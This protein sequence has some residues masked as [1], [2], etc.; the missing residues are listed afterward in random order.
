MKYPKSHYIRKQTGTGAL[1]D[2]DPKSRQ[3]KFYGSIFDK[4]DSDGD[5]FGRSAW[6]KSIQEV[7]P[8]GKNRTKFLRDHNLEKPVAKF[9]AL[10]TDDK[11]LI[12][13]VE[14]GDSQMQVEYIRDLF[15]L[16]DAGV[17]DE[18][19]VGARLIK[20]DYDK[21]RD[22]YEIKEAALFEISAV[23]LAAQDQA[24]LIDLKHLSTDQIDSVVSQMTKAEK[25]LSKGNLT[26]ETCRNLQYQILS[27]KSLINSHKPSD[28]LVPNKQDLNQIK[29]ISDE[30][31]QLTNLFRS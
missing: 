6:D 5:Y 21:E 3:L 1:L 10:Y 15:I 31:K 23:T 28:S 11:G 12:A 7:G 4:I 17:V 26:D 24:V 27:W 14:V 29:T 30:L 25:L 13:E 20:G 18:F 16:M 8:A 9:K 2:I 19:S 22:A